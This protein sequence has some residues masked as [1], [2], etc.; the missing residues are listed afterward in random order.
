ME[1][2]LLRALL[3]LHGVSD[4][5]IQD[6][7]AA[8]SR[9]VASLTS[10]SGAPREAKSHSCEAKNEGAVSGGSSQL[11]L[12]NKASNPLHMNET[13]TPEP[14]SLSPSP[15]ASRQFATT[16]GQFS[17]A[18]QGVAA[19]P[20]TNDR[21]QSQSCNRNQDSGQSTPCETAA[22]IISSMQS[23]P[24]AQ[25]VRSKLGCQSSTSCMVRNMDIFQ[26]LDEP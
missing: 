25:D 8:H 22:N 6:F 26:L 17:G 18:G 15:V 10:H 9:D 21:P 14:T 12:L 2:T 20:P 11:T 13:V 24:D 16:Q 4:N 23:Y 1:N 5:D 19:E 7:L 3:R